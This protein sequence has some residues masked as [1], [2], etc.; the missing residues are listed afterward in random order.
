[1][2][3]NWSLYDEPSDEEIPQ[4]ICFKCID[5]DNKLNASKAFVALYRTRLLPEV[6]HLFGCCDFPVVQITLLAARAGCMKSCVF[7]RI[8]KPGSLVLRCSGAFGRMPPVAADC[9]FV[10]LLSALSARRSCWLPLM[11]RRASS[12]NSWRRHCQFV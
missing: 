7:G 8:R 12:H 9:P 3:F 5:E 4:Y 10:H 11:G 1:M 6:F 2:E